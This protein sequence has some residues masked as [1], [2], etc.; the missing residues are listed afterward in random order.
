MAV[1]KDK[2]GMYR[3]DLGPGDRDMYGNHIKKVSGKE[4]TDLRILSYG[5]DGDEM[6]FNERK[7]TYIHMIKSKIN[8]IEVN[9]KIV[10]Y[11]FDVNGKP[12][13]KIRQEMIDLSLKKY[14]DEIQLLKVRVDSAKALMNK[15]FKKEIRKKKINKLL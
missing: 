5:P 4:R 3:T 11:V 15:R 12:D 14:M 1:Y 10:H 8:E 7:Y 6:M 2:N 13:D 9:H